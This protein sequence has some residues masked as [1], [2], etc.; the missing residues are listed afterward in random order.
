VET[1]SRRTSEIRAM[2]AKKDGRRLLPLWFH[3]VFAGTFGALV[4]GFLV[5]RSGGFEARAQSF[6]DAIAQTAAPILNADAMLGR[7]TA[8]PAQGSYV[9]NGMNVKYQTFGAS[10][11]GGRTIIEIENLMAR[12]GYVHRIL[13]V[14]GVPT[15]VGV[16]PDT[17]VMIMARPG[18]DLRGNPAIRLSQL[19]L[20]EL[21]EDFDAEIPGVPTY[22][23]ATGK[24]LITS[25]DSADSASLMYAANGSVDD[26]RTYY[27]AEMKREGWSGIGAPKMPGPLEGGVIFFER[28]GREA[29]VLVSEIP[30]TAGALVLVTVGPGQAEV[31]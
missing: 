9:L 5:L 26:I 13:L 18:R 28:G 19:N 12:A 17:K 8:E 30:R 29:S 7:R 1:H 6:F 14:Q 23:G 20:S 25:K 16:H 22:P 15:L 2:K 10:R 24:M 3:L 27:L 31:G 11:G 4:L 21:R